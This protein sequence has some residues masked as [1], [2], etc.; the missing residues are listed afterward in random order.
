MYKNSLPTCPICLKSGEAYKFIRDHSS[1]DG[2]FSLLECTHTNV[3]FWVPFANPGSDW[4]VKKYGFDFLDKR[5]SPLRHSAEFFL[6][7]YKKEINGKN[8]LDIGCGTGE[9]LF[10]AK[11]LGA[12]VYGIDFNNSALKYAASTYEL[13]NLH[14]I[15]SIHDLNVLDLPKFD[16]ISAFD[17]VEHLDNLAILFS[18]IEKRLLSDNGIFIF[19]TPNRARWFV[20][21]NHFDYPPNHLM[22]FDANSLEKI[23]NNFGFRL[24]FKKELDDIELFFDT[25]GSV[26]FRRQAKT[27]AGSRNNS[28]ERSVTFS[29]DYIK[30]IGKKLILILS[31]IKEFFNCGNTLYGEATPKK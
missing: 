19:S 28:K 16:F 13:D 4:Y 23:F 22:R 14:L 15:K 5:T 24:Y 25:I 9:F 10:F 2:D 31:K 11:K 20:E 3:Q 29:R 30:K 1:D 17:V 26:V 8:I 18:L 27:M 21:S 7:K 12:N 6:K